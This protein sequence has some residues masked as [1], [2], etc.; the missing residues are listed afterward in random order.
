MTIGEVE[1]GPERAKFEN[2]L[3]GLWNKVKA[4]AKGAVNVARKGIA[5]VRTV[6]PLGRLLDKLKQLIKPLLRRIL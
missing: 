4:L 1:G 5:A 6:I 2:F 3:G